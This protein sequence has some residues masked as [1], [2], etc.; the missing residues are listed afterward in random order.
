MVIEPT[1]IIEK[2]SQIKKISAG[3]SHTAILTKSGELL[4]SGSN[5]KGALGLGEKV[6]QV[7]KFTPLIREDKIVQVS[8]GECF[9]VF[10][11]NKRQLFGMGNGE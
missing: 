9:T 7:F 6:K 11:N 2:G 1:L 10:L 3:Y 5:A 4:M 8:C